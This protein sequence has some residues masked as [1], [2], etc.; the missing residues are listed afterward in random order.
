MKKVHQR[1]RFALIMAVVLCLGMLLGACSQ[2][3]PSST[4]SSAPSS[5]A[6]SQPAGEA[7][8]TRTGGLALPLVDEPTTITWMVPSDVENLNDLAVIQEISRRTG[9]TIEL[10]P[11]P[12]KSYAEKLN[13][14]IGGGDLPD[15]V[16]G[17]LIADAN[18]YGQMGAFADITDYV[19]ELPNFKSLFVDDAENSWVLYSW[20]SDDGSMYKWPIYG[21]ARDVNHGLLY[22]ADVFEE[23]GIEPWTN[24]DE[25]YDALAKVKEAYPDAYPFSS[26][27][28]AALFKD[29]SKYWNVSDSRFPFY[30]DEADGRWK[31]TGASEGY[32][33][34]LDLLKKMY[35]NGLLDPEFLTD[36][37][38]TWSAKMTT[39][40]SFV[41]WD[42]IGRMSLLKGQVGDANPGFDLQF[43]R[44]VGEGK[45][46]TLPKIDSFGPTVTKGENELA[47]LK[48]LDYLTSPEGSELFTV[49][50]EG[51]N[52][53]F[54]GNGTPVYPEL[55]DEPLV[56]INLLEEKYGMWIEG[57]YLRPD[58]RS[59]YYNYTEAEQAA[60]DLCNDVAGYNPND[61]ELKLTDEE[62]EAYASIVVKVTQEI[63][64]F[65][66]KYVT[67]ASYGDA[68]WEAFAASAGE[69][70]VSEALEILNAAQARFDESV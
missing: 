44:P 13:T 58:H 62:T 25:F 46:H 6:G 21:L 20:A 66:S 68:Q 30:Y 65:S 28:G 26:K 7:D 18:A 47:A 4:P 37:Q 70:G 55:A 61:P 2:Q 27:N 16:N 8:L 39:D 10:M 59:V 57:S 49:G 32:K 23:L 34:M 5:S 53:E 52:F 45:Q 22:R 3:A 54:D 63:E 42:W 14:M 24:T 12:K 69:M 60:Q 15:I 51:V 38:D 17:I 29:L 36:T 35:D 19:D 56:D 43:G 9:I 67:D 64:T 33:E 41:A 11:Y 50:I 40:K 1:K 31:F 48:L